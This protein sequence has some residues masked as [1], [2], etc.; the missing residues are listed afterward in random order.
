MAKKVDVLRFKQRAYRKKK[1]LAGFMKKLGK[2]KPKGIQAIIK[3]A[4]KEAFEEIDCLG[5]ANC[6]KTM[7]P[8]Y[9]HKDIRRISAHLGMTKEAFFDK[10]LEVRDDGDICNRFNPCQFLGK[11]NKCSIYAVRPDDCSGFPH[12]VKRDFYYQVEEGTYIE[13]LHRCPATLRFVEKIHES[14][15]ADL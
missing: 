14:I 3:K 6:C 8:T 4:N 2:V 12:H 9:T 11:D 5:C 7:T 15:A 10:W 1:M 13:N